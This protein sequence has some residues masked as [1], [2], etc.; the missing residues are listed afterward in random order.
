MLLE[1][2]VIPLGGGRSISA[3]VAGLIE[4]ID[5]S[6]LD[7]QVT[8]FGTLI[9]GTWDE[10]MQVLKTCHQAMR[11]KSSRMLFLMRLDD[12][13]DRTGLL[14]GAVTSVETVLGR[15]VRK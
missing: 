6:G 12:Y 9:E 7:Y 15:P 1:L 10:L 2:T 13:G 14:R 11:Q 5:Q 8:A 4:L 3:D